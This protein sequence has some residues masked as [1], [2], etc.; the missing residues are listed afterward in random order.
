MLEGKDC[1]IRDY[2]AVKIYI[3][4]LWA[5]SSCRLVDGYQQL[6]GTYCFRLLPEH[7]KLYEISINTY[8]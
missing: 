1:D 7:S 6:G 3:V 2:E 5:M 4:V 8:C